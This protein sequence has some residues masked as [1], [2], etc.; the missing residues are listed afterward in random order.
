M[1]F[2]W[3]QITLLVIMILGLGVNLSD[4]ARGSNDDAL[5]FFFIVLPLFAFVQVLLYY[6]GF[7]T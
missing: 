5:G 2:E 1:V 6:G 3:P 7:W 4:A